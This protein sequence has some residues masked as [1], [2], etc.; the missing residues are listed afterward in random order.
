MGRTYSTTEQFT[1]LQYTEFVGM[2]RSRR[3]ENTRVELKVMAT[4]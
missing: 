2:P 3:E 1:N 4:V